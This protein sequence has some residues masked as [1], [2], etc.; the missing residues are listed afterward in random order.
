MGSAGKQICNKESWQ[1]RGTCLPVVYNDVPSVSSWDRRASKFARIREQANL[2]KHVAIKTRRGPPHF[3]GTYI[4][5][6]LQTSLHIVPKHAQSWRC[7][8]K[9]E[10]E[11]ET[12]VSLSFH[13]LFLQG[14]IQT[15]PSQTSSLTFTTSCIIWLDN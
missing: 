14:V 3:I 7:D 2:Q 8:A 10:R 4:H 12:M 15:P 6:A 1:G 11:A 5:F 9:D 13:L